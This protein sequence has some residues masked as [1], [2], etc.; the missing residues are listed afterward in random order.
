[1]ARIAVHR[2]VRSS[3]RKA[4]VVLLDL[5][6]ADLPSLHGMALLAVRSQ[7]PAVNIRVAILATLPDIAEHGFYVALHARNRLMHA[8]Q[9][10]SRLVMIEFRN[11]ADRRPSIRGVTILAR[12]IQI[13]VRAVRTCRFLRSSGKSG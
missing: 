1:M 9:W 3:E 8:A 4:I 7:L 12:N 11:S 5:L 2:R 6:H 10:I 13:S